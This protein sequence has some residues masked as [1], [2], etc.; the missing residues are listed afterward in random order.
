MSYF[1]YN[2]I[3]NREKIIDFILVLF[4]EYKRKRVMVK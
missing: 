3:G 4:Y 1:Y 2:I